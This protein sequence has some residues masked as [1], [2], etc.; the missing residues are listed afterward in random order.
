MKKIVL[1]IMTILFMLGCN[2]NAESGSTDCKNQGIVLVFKC[3]DSILSKR[4]SELQDLR[5]DIGSIKLQG[6]VVPDTLIWKEEAMAMILASDSTKFEEVKK[7][8]VRKFGNVY[9]Q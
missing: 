3:M 7:S 1:S 6:K 8:V 9:Y 5:I 2:P 4:Q